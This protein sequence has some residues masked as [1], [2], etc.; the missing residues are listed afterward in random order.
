VFHRFRLIRVYGQTLFHPNA[1]HLEFSIQH[2][3]ILH[4][5]FNYCSSVPRSTS[6]HVSS[7]SKRIPQL[8]SLTYFDQ[9]CHLESDGSIFLF[10]EV[11]SIQIRSNHLCHSTST[12]SLRT[13]ALFLK[14][15]HI[16]SSNFIGSD[17]LVIMTLNSPNH[18]YI[19]RANMMASSSI[20]WRLIHWK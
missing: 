14:W 5:Y 10:E 12:E 17:L 19:L 9:Y 16:V 18:I 1:S 13:V 15:C 8:W 7:R 6:L 4:L 20:L 11:P 3:Q 2:H